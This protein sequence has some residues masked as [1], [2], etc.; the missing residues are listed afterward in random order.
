[1][2]AARLQPLPFLEP[3]RLLDL[4]D[5]DPSLIEA[6]L[7]IVA[8]HVALP[9]NGGG[10]V[11]DALAS[12]ARGSCVLLRIIER[13]TPRIIEGTLAARGWI[14][15]TL[16]TLRILRPDLGS[17]NEIRCVLLAS[18]LEEAAASLLA[19]LAGSAPEVLLVHAFDSPAGLALSVGGAPSGAKAA[20][21]R[22]RLSPAPTTV[23]E[24]KTSP[25]AGIPLTADEV[26]EFRKVSSARPHS[27]RSPSPAESRPASDFHPAT[28]F[29]GGF[30]EN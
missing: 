25:L 6:G 7:R 22:S 30:L 13:I 24:M 2:P 19:L 23:A 4:V 28:D 10:I 5:Q 3:T 27:Q 9:V 8:R 15:D 16:P 14:S 17:S 29:R 21:G 1:L 12:D 26:A 11:L 18:G 20:G